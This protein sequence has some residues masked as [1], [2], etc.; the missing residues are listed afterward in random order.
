MAF[1]FVFFTRDST[2]RKMEE[3]MVKSIFRR[4]DATRAWYT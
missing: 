4:I 3:L 1:F 2:E